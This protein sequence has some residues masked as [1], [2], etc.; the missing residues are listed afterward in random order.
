MKKPPALQQG[1][2]AIIVSPAG[3]IDETLVRNAATVLSEW[4]LDVTIAQHAL[5]ESG[6]FSGFVEQRLSDLQQAMD[7]PNIRLIFCSRGGYGVTHLL[8]KLNFAGIK[9]NP[10]W[11]VG[12]SDITALHTALQKEGIVSIHAPM[13]KHFSDEGSGDV[14][15]RYTKA[16]LAGQSVKYDILTTEK[17]Y[18]NRQGKTTGRLFGGNLTVFCGL[19][20]TPYLKVPKNGILCIE[21]IGEAPYKIDRM[22]H[23]LK[24]SG[25]LSNLKGLIVGQFSDYEEDN[26]MYAALYESIQSAVSEYTYPVCFDFPMG[27]V[28]HNFPMLLGARVSLSVNR[29]RIIL[30]Q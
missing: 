10:K 14:S 11:I 25:I 19:L 26:L 16:L 13:A 9:Q 29:E 5:C 27:H 15:V 18:L 7:D 22:I 12:Y 8:D 17:S 24:L 3:K 30:R 21:D 28:K 1:N 20:G 23:Q 6:R 4:G 2:K